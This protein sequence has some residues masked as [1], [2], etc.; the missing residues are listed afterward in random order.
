MALLLLKTSPRSWYSLGTEDRSGGGYVVGLDVDAGMVVDRRQVEWHSGFRPVRSPLTQSTW[1]LCFLSYGLPNTNGNRGDCRTKKTISSWW[2]P[3]MLILTGW[4]TLWTSDSEAP[5]RAQGRM[6]E[7]SGTVEMPILLTREGQMKL[8][9]A[10]ESNRTGTW[11]WVPCQVMRADR[12]DWEV[13][14]WG[15]KVVPVRI[16]SLTDG[17]CLLTDIF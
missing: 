7:A 8:A 11:S 17:R 2:F 10:P 4:V 3:E 1:G 9:S 12:L 6:G 14:G 16:P 13:G 5:V 15:S